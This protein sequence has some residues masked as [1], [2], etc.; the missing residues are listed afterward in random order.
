MPALIALCVAAVAGPAAGPARDSLRLGRGVAS[1]ASAQ[2]PPAALA[3]AVSALL[4]ALSDGERLQALEVAA[5]PAPAL[6]EA[7]RRRPAGP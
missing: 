2:R 6:D 5:A 1:A 4:P 7:R 3:L